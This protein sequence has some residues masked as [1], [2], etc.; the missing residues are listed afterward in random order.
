MTAPAAAP[1]RLTDVRL[2]TTRDVANAFGVEVDTVRRWARKGKLTAI[3]IPGGAWRFR[4]A[5]V[6]AILG[7]N[8]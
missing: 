1:P 8:Q 3:Q 2:L 4:E 5:D 7:G 6:L